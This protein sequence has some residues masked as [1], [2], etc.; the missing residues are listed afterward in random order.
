MREDQVISEVLAIL[1]R[2]LTKDFHLY[3][4]GS[5]ALG[6]QTSG[7][8]FDFLI[9][10][11]EKID[12]ITMSRI[13]AEIEEIPTLYSVDLTDKCSI[14]NEFYRTIEEDLVDVTSGKA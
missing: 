13:Q 6:T 2:H 14:D 10:A 1:K 7:S 12:S 8:D 5:R 4:F 11:G 9:D 3:L